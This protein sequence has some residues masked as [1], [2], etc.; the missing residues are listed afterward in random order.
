MS[1]IDAIDM[2]NIADLED[3]IKWSSIQNKLIVT[4]INGQLT[5]GDNIAAKIV[6]FTFP[7]A[8][9]DAVINHTLSTV[10]RGYILIGSDVAMSLYDGTQ[11]SNDNQITLKSSAAGTARILFF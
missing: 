8:N 9:A 4:I 2:S 11:P 7:T 1:R 6:S 10:P 5:F 3:F